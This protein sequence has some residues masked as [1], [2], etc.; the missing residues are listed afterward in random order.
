MTDREEAVLRAVIHEINLRFEGDGPEAFDR[1]TTL[2]SL[3]LY[4]RNAEKII[5]G[6]TTLEDLKAI[7]E[8]LHPQTQALF[9]L[10]P[11]PAQAP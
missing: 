4:T 2:D 6:S 10:K 8:S 11:P 9:K 7:G 1:E 3:K 5:A